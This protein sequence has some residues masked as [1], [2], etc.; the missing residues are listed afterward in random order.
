MEQ[1]KISL[2]LCNLKIVQVFLQPFYLLNI[3]LFINI[4]E[5]S[6]R[7]NRLQQVVLKEDTSPLSRYAALPWYR[8]VHLQKVSFVQNLF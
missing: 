1:K 4:D 7:L 2:N 6:T 3:Q 5:Q 8:P